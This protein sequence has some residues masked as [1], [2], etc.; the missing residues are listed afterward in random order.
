MD[1]EL[2]AHEI[3]LSNKDKITVLKPV[4]DTIVISCGGKVAVSKLL[5]SNA[6]W[7][8]AY[9]F[10]T[11]FYKLIDESLK[12]Q[13]SVGLESSSERIQ[14][15]KTC[16]G[17]VLPTSGRKVLIATQPIQNQSPVRLEFSPSRFT[18]QD[19]SEFRELWTALTYG[20]LPLANLLSD[21][22]VT[23]LDV[24]VD[25]L[26]IR[27][28]DVFIYNV[29]VWKVWSA[30]SLERGIETQSFYKTSGYN[31]GAQAN[32]KK[33]ANLLVYDKRK[34]Q[35]QK[36]FDPLYGEI[37]HTR[38]ELSLRK[39]CLIES[40]ANQPYLF[41]GWD[42]R[43]MKLAEPP[44]EAGLWQMFLDSARFRGYNAATALAPDGFLPED[45]VGKADKYLPADLI[46]KELIW[47]HWP[48]CVEKSRLLE[49]LS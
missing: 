37:D 36:G 35:K 1:K 14:G 10:W 46:T 28:R 17:L 9:D 20:E 42:V 44:L 29:D 22:K 19:V 47:P 23:R 4:I 43:R 39:Q 16:C 8:T 15:Y 30:S 27:P 5:P 24:A 3:P 11:D 33:R 48:G 2:I 12:A 45:M 34:E 31:Q 26:G 7:Q 40:L 21:A 49:L 38:V 6:Q 32:P 41:Q 18:S 25:L 13:E